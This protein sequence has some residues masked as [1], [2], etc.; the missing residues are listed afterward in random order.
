MKKLS[1]VKIWSHQS[2]G[3]VLEQKQHTSWDHTPITFSAFYHVQLPSLAPGSERN[4]R[5]ESH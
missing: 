2:M 1:I 5:D 3:K 4:S